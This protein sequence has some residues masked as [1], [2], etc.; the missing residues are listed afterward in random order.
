[1]LCNCFAVTGT[2]QGFFEPVEAMV[3]KQVSPIRRPIIRPK[4]SQ[5]YRRVRI[6]SAN[7]SLTEETSSFADKPLDWPTSR[8]GLLQ[9]GN[10]IF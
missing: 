3:I 2:P 7:V 6:G 8:R 5:K 9:E 4:I 1:M 10:Q